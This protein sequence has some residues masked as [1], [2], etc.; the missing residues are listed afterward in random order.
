MDSTS[1]VPNLLWT[2]SV[3]IQVVADLHCLTGSMPGCSSLRLNVC[4]LCRS[5]NHR[6]VALT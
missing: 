4:L 2:D 6:L 3:A 1:G 5:R